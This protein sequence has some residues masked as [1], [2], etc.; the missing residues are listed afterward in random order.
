[1]LMWPAQW[2]GDADLG[3][4]LENCGFDA[5]FGELEGCVAAGWSAS[6]DHYLRVADWVGGWVGR[7]SYGMMLNCI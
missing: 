6:D 5:S 4:L 1:M 7:H 3:V 2:L